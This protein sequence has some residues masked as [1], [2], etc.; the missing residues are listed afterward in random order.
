MLI[1]DTFLIVKK[2]YKLLLL[3]LLLLNNGKVDNNPLLSYD[4]KNSMLVYKAG[5]ITTLIIRDA[6]HQS[7]HMGLNFIVNF[8]VT[9]AGGFPRSG[10]KYQQF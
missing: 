8:F 5:H 3:L 9:L 4:A 10:R 7:G 1:I 6:H 2:I